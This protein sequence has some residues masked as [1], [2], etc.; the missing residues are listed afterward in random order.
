[1]APDEA[2]RFIAE[3]SPA[4]TGGC[5]GQPGTAAALRWVPALGNAAQRIS[6]GEAARDA[7]RKAGYRPVRMFQASMSGYASGS[8]VARSMAQQYC[9]AL[10]DPI[11]TD[12]GFHREGRSYWIVLAAPFDPPERADS[13][14]VAARVLAL[15]NEA[16]SQA[17]K[18]GDAVFEPAPPLKHNPL[19][20]RAATLHAQDMAQHGYL[21]HE[22]RD[23]STPA[24]RVARAGYRW[25]SVGENIASGQ[26][27]AETVVREWLRSPPHC[28][29]LMRPSYTEMGSAFAVNTNSAGGIYWAQAFGRPM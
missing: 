13:A 2:R 4:R 8:A 17:R 20:E 27:T 25:R 16:R 3:I 7:L 6:R 15:T 29:T 11:L 18:C 22:G 19:L 28:A 24:Q 10:T 9:Q 21:E 26:T 23:G 1:V 12:V 5:G 14:S